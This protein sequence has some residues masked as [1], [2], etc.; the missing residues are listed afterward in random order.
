MSLLC[1]VEEAVRSC[2]V[3]QAKV[4]HRIQLYRELLKSL[5]PQPEV[6]FEETEL[7]GAAPTGVSPCDKED[8]ELLEKAL[9]KALRVRTG[10]EPSKKDSKLPKPGK[11][12][13]TLGARP[14]DVTHSSAAS[15]G[16]Q[17]TIR[18][19]TKSASLD[20]KGYRRPGLSVCS[21]LASG[22]LASAD[23]GQTKTTDNRNTIQNH[24]ASSAGALHHQASRKLQQAVVPSVSPD[25]IT[26]LL[27]KNK[28]IRSNMSSGND[29]RKAVPVSAN[30]SN[31]VV[32]SSQTNEPGACS[33]PQQ[34]G[35]IPSEQTTKWKSLKSKQSRLWDKAVAL[36]RN[37]GPGRSH[38]MER[39]RATFPRNWP[40]GSPYETR[41][42]LDRLIHQ[43]Q[44]LTQLCGEPLTKQMP[45]ITS[46]LVSTG[47]KYDSCMSLERLQLT[48]AELQN[49][50]DQV[51]QEWKA[52]DR[53]RPEGGCFC[54]TGA[55]GVQ[56]DGITSPLPLTITYAT[57]AELQ[58]L[59]QL[60]MRV[61]LLQQEVDLE[62]A[63]L[64]TLSP[65]L[66][67]IV[68]GPECLSPSVLRDI[69]SLLGEGG[70]RFP[71]IVLDSEPA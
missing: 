67:A 65:Q 34:N 57:E 49:F 13:G 58:E 38:F 6:S 3:E 60:R 41:A 56:G 53:W 59:E 7:A 29:L 70:E 23:P 19:S 68:P 11:E 46:R 1:A 47:D 52:W 48:A 14:V 18:S 35:R 30:S 8:I 15:R 63:L 64:D 4:N 61:A 39:M 21:S 62:Q 45:E 71:A 33:L 31:N 25:H 69:Y 55:N 22:P 24:P 5:T 40:F 28:T 43:G 44:D 12:T 16:S 32:S 27:S 10:S 66:S 50:A 37:P 17:R 20:R 2:K 9:E 42:L 26:S 36:Q 54:P 51:K